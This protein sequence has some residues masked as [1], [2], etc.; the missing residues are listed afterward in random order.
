MAEVDPRRV[1]R[2]LRNLLV[3][4]V[5]H[6]EGNDIVVIVAADRDAVAVA[7]RDHGVGLKPGE[8]QM[9]FDRFWRAEP[10]PA[11]APGGPAPR[12]FHSPRAAPVPGGRAHARGGY[13]GGAP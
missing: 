7:V 1:E 2:I 10:A 13:R 3:N 6:G 5:E 4:A 8:A 11:R 12:P 9:V